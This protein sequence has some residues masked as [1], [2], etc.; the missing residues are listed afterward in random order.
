MS[1]VSILIVNCNIIIN[2]IC[3]SSVTITKLKC[4]KIINERIIKYF[5]NKR[6]F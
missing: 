1:Q 4:S 5:K 6:C 2:S 3:L